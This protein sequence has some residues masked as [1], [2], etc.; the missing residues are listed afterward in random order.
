MISIP[1]VKPFLPPKEKLM[2]ELEG[3][4]YS[5]YI[6]QG[7]AVETFESQM[8][9]F[10]QVD[11]G[12]SLNSGTSALQLALTVA[13]VGI[14]DEV[15]STPL[16]AEPTN[17]AIVQSGAKLV[18]A[19]ISTNDGNISVDSLKKQITDK[20][21]AIVIVHYAGYLCDINE[22]SKLC[23][24]RGIILIEDAA[25]A[26]G[27]KYEGRHIGDKCDFTAFS[28]QAIKH[29]TTVDGGY[30]TFSNA[31]NYKRAKKLRWF[32]L[33]KSKPRADNRIIESGFKYHM[34]NVNATFGL[35]QL[36]YL[37]NNI[38]KHKRNAEFYNQHLLNVEHIELCAVD[39]Y[40]EP[41]Y[42]LYTMKVKNGLRDNLSEYLQEHG[43][44]ASTLH[45]RND[46]HPAFNSGELLE[47]P[48]LEAFAKEFI[49][50]PCG[51]WVSEN[52]AKNIVSLIIEWAESV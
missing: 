23:K 3:I 13:N 9:E 32:G 38:N 7:D 25:H 17:T 46:V 16:T 27:S 22:I 30:L 48:N 2:P 37:Q 34:N 12:L 51:W 42:W 36:C 19:D 11:Y 20:T 15:I 18:F 44:G 49:H 14:G 45:T 26:L 29:M 50:I 33:D 47:L 41:S 35:V 39:K 40:S 8:N 21:K 31:N 5:G 10:L 52:D 43:V 4:I 6:A 28:F 1:L 24:S